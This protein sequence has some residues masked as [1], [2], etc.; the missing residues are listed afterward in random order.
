MEKVVKVGVGVLLINSEW[1]ILYGLRKSKHGENTYGPPGW[2]LEFGET[3]EACAIRELFEESGIIALEKDVGIFGIVND[4]YQNN[5]QHY[6]SIITLIRH[7]WGKPENKEPEK[8]EEWKWLSWE[9]IKSFWEINFYTIQNFI[10]KY[11][12]FSPIK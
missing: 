3:I 10:K 12:D 4:L 1:K 5:E 7:T 2:H 8:L 9:E 11:P 6:I